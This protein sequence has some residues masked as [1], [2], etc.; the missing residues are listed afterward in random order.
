VALCSGEGW[1]FY[2]S[3]NSGLGGIFSLAVNSWA[4]LGELVCLPLLGRG[5]TILRAF[6]SSALW[7]IYQTLYLLFRV[8]ECRFTI[9]QDA[10]MHV[11][12]SFSGCR[13]H[14]SL[15]GGDGIL[16]HLPQVSRT[17]K[18]LTATGERSDDSSRCFVLAMG[19]W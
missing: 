6:Y 7:Q 8:Q 11:Y 18:Y 9:P 3:F 12:N 5:E 1:S 4:F 19:Q 10:G 16:T 2:G 17:N 13:N 14:S 15:H